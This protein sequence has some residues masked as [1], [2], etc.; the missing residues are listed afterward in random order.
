MIDSVRSKFSRIVTPINKNQFLLE[1]ETNYAKFGFQSDE[2]SLNFVDIEGGPFLHIGQD[3]F[4]QGIVSHIEKISFLDG[5]FIFKITL[6]EKN[7]E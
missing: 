6:Q 3:F 7:N 4:G 2:I 5:Q 1:G